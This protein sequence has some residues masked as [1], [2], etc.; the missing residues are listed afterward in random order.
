MRDACLRHTHRRG[1]RGL[2]CQNAINMVHLALVGFEVELAPFRLHFPAFIGYDDMSVGFTE[3]GFRVDNESVCF[4]G[5]PF[6]GNDDIAASFD[7]V[8]RGMLLHGIGGYFDGLFFRGW[9]GNRWA[10]TFLR[11]N[12]IR[13]ED[14]PKNYQDYF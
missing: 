6:V 10:L 4:N 5:F 3:A 9:G 1:A 7:Q 2:F 12:F 13:E 14:C 11:Q 8:F